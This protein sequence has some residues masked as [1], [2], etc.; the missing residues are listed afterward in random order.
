[1]SFVFQVPVVGMTARTGKNKTTLS[2]FEDDV[3][4]ML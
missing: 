3:E 2:G 4:H 1:M